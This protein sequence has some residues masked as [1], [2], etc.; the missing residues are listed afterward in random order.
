[1]RFAGR[2]VGLTRSKKR[3]NKG[4]TNMARK[5]KRT[6]IMKYLDKNPNASIKQIIEDMK[7]VNSYAY[8]IRA[9]WRKKR[10]IEA[11]AA[12][13]STLE[14]N[15]TTTTIKAV[16]NAPKSFEQPN[17]YEIRNAY[18]DA[19]DEKI[20]RIR[21]G[22]QVLEEGHVSA[23]DDALSFLDDLHKRLIDGVVHGYNPLHFDDMMSLVETKR[24][25]EQCFTIKSRNE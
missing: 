11:A 5:S 16:A 19:L 23:I 18:Q 21:Q 1:M 25:L 9:E 22:R 15:T 12:R 2:I 13:P 7:C 10:E 24:N 3:F 17:L 8:T 20:H 6:K 14:S 4:E